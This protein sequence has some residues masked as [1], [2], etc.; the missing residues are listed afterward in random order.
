M[1]YLDVCCL[2]SNF[3]IRYINRYLSITDFQFQYIVIRWHILFTFNH[4]KFIETYQPEYSFG[5]CYMCTWKLQVISC[6]WVEYSL[7]VRSIWLIVLFKIFSIFIDFLPT[8]LLIIETGMLKP[9]T[10]TMD[11]PIFSPILL[12]L[13]A[14][15]I[16]VLC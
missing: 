9:P 11:L 3:L 4:L 7:N 1:G 12:S 14:S 5:D 8:V 13:F 16:L 10:T 6:C 15:Y 2:I